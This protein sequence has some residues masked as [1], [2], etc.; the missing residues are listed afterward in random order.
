M[1]KRNSVKNTSIITEKPDG[2]DGCPSIDEAAGKDTRVGGKAT[3]K[4][5]NHT[6]S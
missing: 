2:R 1:E 4:R 5:N 6:I 3:L